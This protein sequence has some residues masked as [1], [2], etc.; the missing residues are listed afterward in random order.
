MN[1]ILQLVQNKQH[2]VLQLHN[3]FRCIASSDVEKIRHELLL[4]RPELELENGDYARRIAFF[5][6]EKRD[7]GIKFD[8]YA[9][10]WQPGIFTPWHLHL[11]NITSVACID[12]TFTELCK[13]ESGDFIKNIYNTK[14]T[15][16]IGDK[17]KTHCI[18][19]LDV[20]TAL[21]LHFKTCTT[22]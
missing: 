1:R 16:I 15:Y 19:N 3:A 4:H 12:G 10:I 5:H 2:N 11:N 18:G 9:A 7:D 13:N 6:T 8:I 17:I 21:S 14:D 20:K 22:N